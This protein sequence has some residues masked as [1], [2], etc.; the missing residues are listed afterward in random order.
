MTKRLPRS[1]APKRKDI[2]LRNYDPTVLL[3]G[4]KSLA[5]GHAINEAYRA[6]G[7][8]GGAM[9][10]ILAHLLRTKRVD[11][12][13]SAGFHEDDPITPRY[14]K[15]TTTDDIFS[16][17]GSIYSYLSAIPLRK[18]VDAIDSERCAI[19]CQPCMVPLLRR[20]QAQQ[21]NIKYIFSFFCGY[22]MS[23]EAT[24]FMLRKLNVRPEEVTAINYRGGPYPGGFQLITRDGQK[25]TYGKESY[26][27]LNLQ[28]VRP[29]CLRCTKY[30]GEGADL[31]AGDAWLKSHPRMTLLMARSALGKE[32]M[33]Q[34]SYDHEVALYSMTEQDLLR[35]HFHNLIHKKYGDGLFLRLTTKMFNQVIPKQLVPF[36][37]L[38]CFSRLR[39][40]WKIG[41]D[42]QNLEP[43]KSD[44]V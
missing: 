40:R 26:E 21:N 27:L 10:T 18:A 17:G 42:I 35:M 5:V 29:G 3:G 22:N 39:R 1:T 24:L 44:C 11:A 20:L 15:Q 14:L 13:I 19:V 32:A 25:F 7:A 33:E 43:Y 9:R 34:A 38:S 41:V 6:T 4:Y 31:V 16:M 12:V 2:K 30:M 28:F 8:S 23:H 37:L 36:K